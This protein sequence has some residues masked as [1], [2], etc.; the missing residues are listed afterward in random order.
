MPQLL[1]KKEKIKFVKNLSDSILED[2]IMRIND[3]R[4]PEEW[5]GFELREILA[6]KFRGEA[7]L[8]QRY[9]SRMR[10]YKNT[11]LVNNI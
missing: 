6:E 8:L 5:D 9:K 7:Y 1:L 4:I 11:V 10:D 3:N 2:I